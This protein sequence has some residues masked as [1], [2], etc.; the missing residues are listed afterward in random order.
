M[1][2]F[3]YTLVTQD[4]LLSPETQAQLNPAQKLTYAARRVECARQLGNV[5]LLAQALTDRIEITLKKEHFTVVMEGVR[6]LVLCID[7]LCTVLENT[8]EAMAYLDRI[9][10]WVSEAGVNMRE[11]LRTLRTKVRRIIMRTGPIKLTRLLPLTIL[12]PTGL[13]HPGFL[14][15]GG[16]P[17]T[18]AWYSGMGT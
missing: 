12:L 2:Y 16:L 7:I 14:L 17:G 18:S 11:E 9:D 10:N 15:S 13:D 3:L 4:H 8:E 5:T 1:R 6:E